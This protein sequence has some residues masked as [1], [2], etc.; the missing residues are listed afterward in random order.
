METTKIVNHHKKSVG[1]EW[2]KVLE[3]NLRR[4]ETVYTCVGGSAWVKEVG[5]DAEEGGYKPDLTAG[6]GFLV[7][8]C[9]PTLS[10]GNT[11][12]YGEVWAKSMGESVCE[13]HIG[14]YIRE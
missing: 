12:Y 6:N 13:L 5:Y 11:M 9:N 10:Y 8:D 2:V 7:H 4:M 1:S 14:E 3:Q